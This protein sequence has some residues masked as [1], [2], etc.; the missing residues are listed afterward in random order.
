MFSVAMPSDSCET[1]EICVEIAV[2]T[3]RSASEKSLDGRTS[4]KLFSGMFH[5]IFA[6]FVLFF[7]FGI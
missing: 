4:L 2:T 3:F 1:S 5:G 7:R 6:V